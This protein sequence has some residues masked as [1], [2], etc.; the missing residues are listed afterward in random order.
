[1]T[2]DEYDFLRELLKDVPEEEE[3][4]QS[5]VATPNS[6]KRK[7]SAS[8]NLSKPADNARG[9]GGGEGGEDDEDDDD[10]SASD[11]NGEQKKAKKIEGKKHRSR[12]N[13]SDL[14]SSDTG[15]DQSTFDR[16]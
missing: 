15:D 9:G 7:A 4:T 6:S 5:F 3:G 12:I 1:M 10:P 14:V 8:P 16:L 2:Y 13:I 11:S